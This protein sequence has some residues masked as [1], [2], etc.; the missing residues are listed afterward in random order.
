MHLKTIPIG[1]VGINNNSMKAYIASMKNNGLKPRSIIYIKPPVVGWKSTFLKKLFG[2]KI[3]YKINS[4]NTA[5]QKFKKYEKIFQDTTR[6]KVDYFSEAKLK[7]CCDKYY[8]VIAKNIND[9]AVVDAINDSRESVF[10]Y[11]GGGIVKDPVFNTG[12]KLI[13]THPGFLPYVRGSHGQYWSLLKRGKFGCTSF[14]MNKGIDTGDIIYQKEF[15][16]NIFPKIDIPLELADKLLLFFVD[17]YIRAATLIDVIVKNDLYDNLPCVKQDN[18]IGETFF[19]M[20]EKL[21]FQIVKKLINKN[22]V[23]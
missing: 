11:G 2:S 7:N 10:I 12:I 3:A 18:T 21:R 8:E 19:S 16:K 6:F 22:D 9:L 13:H 23:G 1:V 4:L 5:P 15:D 14:Y 20:H 17:S